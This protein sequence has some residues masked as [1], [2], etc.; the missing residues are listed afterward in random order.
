MEAPTTRRAN[1]AV[2]W[3]REDCRKLEAMGVLPDRWEL[4]EGDIVSKMG[5]NRPHSMIAKRI[6]VWLSSIFRTSCI[7]PT[8]SID[9]APQDNPTSEPEPDLTLLTRPAADL[10]RN[11]LPSDIALLIEVSDTTIDYDLGPKAGLYARA[12]IEEYW[13][14]NIN[15]RAI[16]QHRE[17][18]P[19]GYRFLRTVTGTSV[20]SPL[21]K[22][23]ATLTPAEI[24]E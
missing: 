9:V 24:F 17:P 6:D 10:D 20:L 15:E 19:K 5:I 23:E 21:A 2:M 1:K 18:S 13:V 4:V 3:T 14:I 8:C 7:L 11:P 12:G 16:H 22:P